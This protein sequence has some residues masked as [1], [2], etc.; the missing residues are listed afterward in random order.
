MTFAIQ[1][2]SLALLRQIVVKHPKAIDIVK[3]NFKAYLALGKAGALDAETLPSVK[4][5]CPPPGNG[6]RAAWN[7]S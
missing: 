4:T 7:D 3:S 6:S 1:R 2:R 5:I